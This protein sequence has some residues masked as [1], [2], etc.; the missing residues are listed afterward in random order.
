MGGGNA[1]ICGNGPSLK[2][3]DY[4]RLPKE[5]DV[6]RCNQFYFEN[7]YYLG[8]NIKYAFF[9]S[10]VFFE[11]YYTAK[12]LIEN[13]EY[14]IENIVCSTFNLPLIDGKKFIKLFPNYFCDCILGH[15]LL[16]NIKDFLAFMLY[17][18]IYESKRMT[19]GIYMCAIAISL[20]Y[21]NIYLSGIDFYEDNSY[22][23]EHK[24]NNLLKLLP[25]FKNQN[26]VSEFHSKEFD[27]QTLAFLK[28][29]YGAH[30]YSLNENSTLA[31]YIDL[32]PI[33]GNH[34]SIENK[35]NNYIS[36]I[37]CPDPIHREAIYSKKPKPKLKQNIYY[38]LFKDFFKLP[39]DIKHYIK[40]K[41]A[42][43]DQ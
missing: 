42:N 14:N 43:K 22:A 27:L 18:E 16:Y 4:K 34:F 8:K 39:S 20:G 19:S 36:D 21:K 11:Q 29:K 1:V 25:K 40:E 17:N 33:N 12:K 41:Y 24:K 31:K 15:E 26:S 38:K 30:F 10:F 23:F 32:A 6:F 9:N 7:K 28:E 13:N 37:L 35:P 2:E 5:Y 3:I